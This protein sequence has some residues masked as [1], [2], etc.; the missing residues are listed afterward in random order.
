MAVKISKT[1]GGVGN[2]N[3]SRKLQEE[4]RTIDSDIRQAGK[5]AGDEIFKKVNRLVENSIQVDLHGLHVA[6]AIAKV[7]ESLGLLVKLHSNVSVQIV[8]GGQGKHSDGDAR[9]KPALEQHL[10]S[11][12]MPCFDKVGS[13]MTR[14]TPSNMD[15]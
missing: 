10:A 4:R 13:L 3:R 7:D 1:N 15:G 8:T 9:L 2:I 11:K 14:V 5:D 6:E 12:G